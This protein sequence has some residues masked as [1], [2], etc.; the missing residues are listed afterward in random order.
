[1]CCQSAQKLSFPV[2]NL[3]DSSLLM[4]ALVRKA[5]LLSGSG[6]NDEVGASAGD[7]V[8]AIQ[9]RQGDL[10]VDEVGVVEN[11]AH[12]V[13]VVELLG[14][15]DDGHLRVV[16]LRQDLGEEVS[17]ADHVCIEDDHQ[18]QAQKVSGRSCHCHKTDE[19]E[20]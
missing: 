6:A 13:V 9:P 12:D 15:E 18:L 1:M 14:T 3:L 5:D 2:D 7:V 4:K 20:A 11:V 17:V 19:M 10:P 16:Q 8:P